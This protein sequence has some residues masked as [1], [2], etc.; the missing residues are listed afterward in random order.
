MVL[1][2]AQPVG[3]GEGG[4]VGEFCQGWQPGQHVGQ[5]GPGIDAE[6]A[7]VL[8][9][10]VEDGG[11][12][13]GVLATDEEPV[14][15][16]ELGRTNGVLDE[17]VVDLDAAVREVGLQLAPLVDGVAHGLAQQALRQDGTALQKPVEEFLQPSV[18]HRALRC[19]ERFPQYGRGVGVT[20]PSFDLIE[21][22]EL[23]QDPCNQP[24]RL[25]ARFEKLPAD[26]RVASHEGDV[27]LSASPRWI[28]AEAVALDHAWQRV[29]FTEQ[30][31]DAAL[32]ASGL[33]VVVDAAAWDVAGSQIAGAGGA[34]AGT[35]IADGC[36][37]D[38]QVGA[39]AVLLVNFAVDR[40]QPVRGEQRPVAEGLAMQVHA[41]AGEQFR[42]PVIG[43]VIGETRGDDFGDESGCGIATLLQAG[44]QGGDHG[45]GQWIAD[46]DVFGTDQPPAQEAPGPVVELLAGFLA[47]AAV[48]GGI[49]QNHGGIDHVFFDGQMFRDARL[50]RLGAF[51]SLWLNHRSGVC[52]R[53]GGG[54]F[55]AS[56][57][58]KS[59]SCAGSSVS[60]FAPKMRRTSASTVCLS[61][62][63]C[64]SR[65]AI[66]SSRCCSC[67]ASIYHSP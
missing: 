49:R 60:L 14:L 44:R 58:N 15:R 46:A 20:Q 23:S 33:P 65:L 9:H 5:I 16:S 64:W 10:G 59:S 53:G 28:G 19:T 2:F 3:G 25:V 27:R 39:G 1:Q 21:M 55:K 52:G 8:H 40:R 37:V 57:S 42:L 29:V 30:T 32:I 51:D 62:A 48:G 26:M 54:F 13:A 24:R 35:E 7:A 18:D 12:P 66:S 34:A 50:A 38:L 61:N 45:L 31:G 11:F 6:A 63:I 36:F 43:L 17:V 4:G 67:A 56:E 47:D 41:L 22:A